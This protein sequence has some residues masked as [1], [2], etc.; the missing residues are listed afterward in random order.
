MES[1]FSCDV[2]AASVDVTSDVLDTDTTNPNSRDNPL[3]F[4]ALMGN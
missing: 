1:I 2:M 4:S 3:V